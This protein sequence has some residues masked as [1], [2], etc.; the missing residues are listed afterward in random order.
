MCPRVFFRASRIKMAE[1]DAEIAELLN[2]IDRYNPENVG[3]LEKFAEKQA[4]TGSY[5]FKANL[6]VLKLYQFNPLLFKSEMASLILLKALTNLPHTDFQ[7]CRSLLHD[8]YQEDKSFTDIAMLSDLLETCQF[9]NFWVTLQNH[10]D[11]IAGIEGFRDSIRKYICHVVSLTWQ[12]IGRAT[13]AKL[14]GDIPALEVDGYIESHQWKVSSD[15]ESVFVANQE[16]TVR[17]KN[18]VEKI[19]FDHVAGVMT[20]G[21]HSH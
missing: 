19:Q 12:K 4:Q 21:A 3:I 6:A 2:S 8:S 7:L 17:P 5:N 11:L 1:T 16:V 9:Q 14:L 20:I 15:G 13:L 10:E 18:I